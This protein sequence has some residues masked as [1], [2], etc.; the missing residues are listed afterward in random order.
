MAQRSRDAEVPDMALSALPEIM[1]TEDLAQ[2]LGI[3]ADALAQDRYRNTRTAD[4]IPYIKIGRRVR[5]LRA[6]V[7]EYFAAHR[8]GWGGA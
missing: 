8:S 5:Y 2:A 4:C 3:T 7:C 1:S 6:D